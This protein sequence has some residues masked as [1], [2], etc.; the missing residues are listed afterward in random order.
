MFRIYQRI[1]IIDLLTIC[2]L[3]LL[4][5]ASEISLQNDLT[6]TMLSFVIIINV[7]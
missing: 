1:P 6:L 2:L 3:L 4:L 5:L 7:S